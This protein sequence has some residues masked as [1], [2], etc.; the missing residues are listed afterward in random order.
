MR[1]FLV[2]AFMVAA[3]VAAVGVGGRSADAQVVPVAN[4]GGPYAGVTGAGILFSGAASTGTNLSFSWT[5]GDGTVSTG[6]TVTKAYANPGIYTVTLT[7][8]D[9]MGQTAS[10]ST[11]ASISIGTGFGTAGCFNTGVGLVCSGGVTTGCVSTFAGLVCS[12]GATTGCFSTFAG[13]V[14]SGGAAA[15]CVN[16]V[17]GLVCTGTAGCVST[18]AG[19]VCAG[20][21]LAFSPFCAQL[22]LVTAGQ[23]CSGFVN[24]G[25]GTPLFCPDARLGFPFVSVPLKC[26]AF[27]P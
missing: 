18:F 20:S 23:F 1:R 12:G 2:M 4:P 10:A 8:V 6:V 15:G 16:T 7:V 5:F 13:L 3:V 24:T 27:A 17:V 14:C 9:N 25:T 26:I 22:G 19:I 21:S 11:T